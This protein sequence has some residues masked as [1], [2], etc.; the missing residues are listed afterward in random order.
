MM[1]HKLTELVGKLQAAHQ[2]RLLSVILYGSAAAGDHHEKFSDLNVFCVLSQVTPRELGESESVFKWW[3]GQGNPAPLLMSEQEVHASTDCFPIEFHDMQERR[4]V[5]FGK[6]L[7]AN[8]TIDRSFYRAQVEHE[9]L[10]KLLRL[11]Q[12]A[13]GLLSDDKALLRL[14]ADSVST[15]LVLARHALLL[16][17]I[18]APW[19]K[20]EIAARLPALGI[21][22]APFDTLLDLRED[23]SKP[24]QAAA[25]ALFADYLKQIEAAVAHVDRLEK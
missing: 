4:R 11:R 7:I 8:L 6:D 19:K 10:S 9:L 20:R 24:A 16:S 22:P 2:D 18:E 17:G 12:Q 25:P 23:K 21:N 14:L 15:F 1:E 13:A 5:L 3:R